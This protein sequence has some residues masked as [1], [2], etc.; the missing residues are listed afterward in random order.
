MNLF[1]A[2]DTVSFLFRYRKMYA[3]SLHRNDWIAGRSKNRFVL[4]VVEYR[5][6]LLQRV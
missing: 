3:N 5:L 2:V 6:Q 4:L 1:I